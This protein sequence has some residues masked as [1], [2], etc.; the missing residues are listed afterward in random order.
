[1]IDTARARGSFLHE[2]IQ[3]T[4]GSTSVK[5]ISVVDTLGAATPET[6]SLLVAAMKEWTTLPIEVHCHN[7][8]GLGVSNMVAGLMAGAQSFSCTINGIGQRAGNASLEEVVLALQ[9]LYGVPSN[10]NLAPIRGLSAYVQDLS[11]IPMPQYKAVVGSKLFNWEAGIPVAALRKLPTSV[12]PFV[13]ELLGEKHSIVLGKKAGKAN[14]LFKL[15]E[16]GLAAT[17]AQITAMVELV[18]AKALEKNSTVSDAEFVQ[19]H[20]SV[21]VSV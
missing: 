15:E 8:F 20:S 12:E 18:K 7:D 13:P 9:Y 2:F 11:N 5:K 3:K 10:L 16:H 1:M 19:I 4:S 21:V 6:I 14:I 17:D